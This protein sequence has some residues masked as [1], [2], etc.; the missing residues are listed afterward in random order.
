MK[1]L[2]F[3]YLAH[4]QFSV[5]RADFNALFHK[6]VCEML[7]KESGDHDRF[8]SFGQCRSNC[9]WRHFV[10]LDHVEEVSQSLDLFLVAIMQGWDH[11]FIDERRLAD[12]KQTSLILAL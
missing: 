4:Q 8:S 10:E 12:H 7:D 2:G 9:K 11:S 5:S 6:H 3:R 1:A